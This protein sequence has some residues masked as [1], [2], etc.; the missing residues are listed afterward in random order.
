MHI[1]LLLPTQCMALLT[2]TSLRINRYCSM[3][4]FPFFKMAVVPYLGF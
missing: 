1:I 4:D 3:A 2:L